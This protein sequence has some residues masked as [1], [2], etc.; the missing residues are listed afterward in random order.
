[1]MTLNAS[2]LSRFPNPS[3]PLF[4]RRSVFAFCFLLFAFF[5]SFAYADPAPIPAADPAAIVIAGQARF[6]VL[7]PRL[8]R[9]EWS[10]TSTFEDRASMTFINR[11]LPVPQFTSTEENGRLTIQTEYLTLQY[12]PEGGL[13]DAENLSIA[14]KAGKRSVTWRPGADPAENLRGT[15]RSLDGASGMMELDPGLISRDGWAV[16]DDTGQA[17]FSGGERPWPVARTDREAIDCYFFGHGHDY[18]AALRDYTLVAGRIPMPPRFV[19]GAWWSRY[20]PYTD[21]ELK[22]LVAEFREHDV[23]LDVLVIDLDWHEPGWSGYTWHKTNFPDPKAFLDWTKE[24]GLQVTLNLHPGYDIEKQEERFKPLASALDLDPETTDKILY[25]HFKPEWVDAYFKYLLHPLEAQGVDFWW[26]DYGGHG[27]P[28]QIEGLDPFLWLNAIHFMDRARDGRRGLMFSRWG[29]LANHRYQ[30]GFSG[31]TY[32]TF[33][34]LLFQ[35]G[36]T[37]TAGNV[38]FPYW[39]HDVGGHLPGPCEPEMYVRWIQSAVFSPTLRTHATRDPGAERR[40]WA[41]PEEYFEAAREAFHLRYSLI[42]YI[43]TAA[44]Q[45]YD[46]A[47]PLCRPL[48]YEWPEIDETYLRSEFLF[49]DSLLVAHVP[50]PRNEISRQASRQVWIPPGEWTHWYTGE[51]ITGPIERQFSS[52]LDE[53]PLFVR[54]GAVIPAMPS[55]K[56]TGEKPVDPLILHIFPGERGETRVYED[57]GLTNGYQT[58]EC[59]WTPVRH[60]LADGKRRITIGPA[61]GSFPGMLTARKYEV[62]LHEVWLP[63]SVTLNGQELAASAWEYDLDSLSL[64]ICSDSLPVNRSVMI[65]VA[66]REGWDESPLRTGLRGRLDLLKELAS[67][68]G[69]AVPES[70]RDVLGRLQ[71]ARADHAAL[72]ALARDVNTNWISLLQAAVAAKAEPAVADRVFAQLAGLSCEISVMSASQDAIDLDVHG[73]A[74]AAMPYGSLGP[75]VGEVEI[76]PA[77]GWTVTGKGFRRSM[78]VARYGLT[79][80]E[81][82]SPEGEPVPGLMRAE[83][84]FRLGERE[85]RTSRERM[86]MPSIDKWWV[87][88]PFHNP[89]DQGVDHVFPPEQGIDVAATYEGKDGKTIGWKKA[90]RDIKP[91]YDFASEF[92]LDLLEFYGGFVGDAVAYGLTYLHAPEDMD[93]VLALGSDDGVAVWVNG[94]EVYRHMAARPYASRQDRVPVKLKAGTNTVLLKVNQGG[95]GWGFGAHIETADGRPL[96]Q[97]RAS[98]EP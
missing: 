38:C 35:P 70:I 87:A 86:I 17:V 56:H 37:A 47:V 9:M 79:H 14:L 21:Q 97:V 24:Q 89:W 2:A 42:P 13:F 60:A 85:L 65:E 73:S 57:D 92:S 58:G 19:F 48:Y 34:T 25:D 4:L 84:V 26:L 22:N 41:F 80:V 10:A 72:L 63:E 6:T 49:G 64:R 93:A 39:S 90:T 29:G 12:R 45:A 43:Y 98:F 32:S 1:M 46:E 77:A 36:F 78:D 53:L 81:K 33:D 83:F 51:T 40:I 66:L 20:W 68:L 18:P 62:V 91:G 31:D 71:Q 54:A 88:G 74:Y 76:K 7:T 50:G 27:P 69:P 75:V 59:A 5:C 28:T 3:I 94:Q 30:I 55:M 52:A 67:L 16:V 95:G 82:C 61:E 15:R 96:P 23:P 44:R 8:I 11:K